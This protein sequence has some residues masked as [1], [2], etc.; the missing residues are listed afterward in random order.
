MFHSIFVLNSCP[1]TDSRGKS[2]YQKLCWQ[3]RQQH[4]RTHGAEIP[5]MSSTVSCCFIPF[6]LSLVF[7]E[8]QHIHSYGASTAGTLVLFGRVH[9][10]I[11]FIVYWM[12]RR[13]LWLERVGWWVSGACV[14]VCYKL[15][16]IFL[17]AIT[18]WP[19][20]FAKL[21]WKSSCLFATVNGVVSSC[22]HL[23]LLLHFIESLCFGFRT[24]FGSSSSPSL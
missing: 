14:I 12:A 5:C 9:Q 1:A 23:R 24:S 11:F 13:F 20:G 2:P 19:S 7:V 17:N 8:T 22:L 4:R 21:L 6:L 10:R 18:F 3:H 16:G 15:G